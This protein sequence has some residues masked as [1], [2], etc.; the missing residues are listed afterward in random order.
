MFLLLFGCFTLAQNKLSWETYYEQLTDIDGIES[1]SW[2]TAYEVLSELAEHPLNLNE[3]K[4]EDLEQL[5]FLTPQQIE[6][7]VEYLDRYAPIRSWGELAMIES[8]DA[9]RRKL[10]SF[11]VTLG[12]EQPKAFP[13]TADI[14]KYG[15]HEALFTGKVPF[16][17]RQ[18]DEKGYLGYPYK[19]WWRYNFKYGQYVNAGLVGSQDAGEPWF[20][21]RNKWG[22]DYYSYYLQLKNWGRLKSMVMGRYR[23]KFGLGVSMNRDFGFGK[24]ATLSALGNNTNTIRAQSSRSEAN[25]MQGVAATV[26]VVRGL[27]LTGFAS[28]RKIDGT[29]RNDDS[30]AIATIVKT[31]YHRT[32]HET[33]S[34]THLTLPTS[35]LV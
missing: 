20:A 6:E 29:L 32:E 22:Y 13:A 18:G 2:E 11:F 3:A 27:D 8:L 12:T 14:M 25:Y 19:H 31:G 17:K 7:L 33:V 16:Y 15:R 34:Y 28:Y 35:D 21:G 4:R 9:T 10:L 1:G 30:T 24:L 26:S 5:P 23:L